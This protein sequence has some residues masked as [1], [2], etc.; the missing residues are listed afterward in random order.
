MTD[1]YGKILS[2]DPE[3]QG[4]LLNPESFLKHQCFQRAPVPCNFVPKKLENWAVHVLVLEPILMA[5]AL[6]LFFFL[7]CSLQD[8]VCNLKHV[9][10][11]VFLIY[12]LFN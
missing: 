5:L 3:T 12:Q 2:H 1:N 4:S 8:H 6:L 10:S 11:Y 7:F 9:S